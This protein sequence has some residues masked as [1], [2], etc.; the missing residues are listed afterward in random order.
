MR[1]RTVRQKMGL[2]AGALLF[3]ALVGGCTGTASAPDS[4]STPLGQELVLDRCTVC[5]SLERIKAADHDREGWIE[6][7]T[8][9]RQAG[10]RL[11]DAE[12]EEIV[13]FLSAG[14]ASQL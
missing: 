12:A 1:L 10:A 8:R 6:T 3:S 7:V 14:G 9:M 13:Q 5:H 2:V 11:S 4:S